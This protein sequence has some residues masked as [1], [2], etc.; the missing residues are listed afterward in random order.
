LIYETGSPFKLATNAPLT[1]TTQ[2]YASDLYGDYPQNGQTW[3]SGISIQNT[4]GTTAADISVTYYNRDGTYAG[5][6]LTTLGPYRLWVLNRGSFNMPG[7]NF[8]GSAVIQSN[9]PIAAVVN[10]NH[11]GSGDKASYTAP[12]R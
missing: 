9:Q 2:A 6:W 1:G 3:N 12:N 10:V 4:S 5:K 11:T 8:V 7:P